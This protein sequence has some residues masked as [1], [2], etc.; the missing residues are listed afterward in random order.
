MKRHVR[1]FQGKR[2]RQRFTE[3]RIKFI[4]SRADK[5]SRTVR[6][7]I[8]DSIPVVWPQRAGPLGN[9]LLQRHGEPESRLIGHRIYLERS[10]AV[11]ELVQSFHHALLR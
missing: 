8:C 7:E 5:V 9:F 2:K 10:D 4:H 11:I 3:T 6:K 1:R